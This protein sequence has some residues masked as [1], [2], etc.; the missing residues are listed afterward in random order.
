[1]GQIFLLSNKFSK[2]KWSGLSDGSK[3]MASCSLEAVNTT[4]FVKGVKDLEMGRLFWINCAVLVV[5]LC[6]TL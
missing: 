3:D 5:Q 1:M 6:L 4:L 2:D